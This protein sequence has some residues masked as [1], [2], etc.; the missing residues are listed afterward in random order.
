[1]ERNLAETID[2]DLFDFHDLL[3]NIKLIDLFDL[4][5]NNLLRNNFLSKYYKNQIRI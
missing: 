1:M 3:S 5:T 4:L 2:D